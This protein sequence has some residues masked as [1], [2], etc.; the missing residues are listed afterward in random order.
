MVS[1]LVAFW[2]TCLVVIETKKSQALLEDYALVKLLKPTQEQDSWYFAKLISM[3]GSQA[4]ILRINLMQWDLMSGRDITGLLIP[5]LHQG[6]TV[7]AWNWLSVC[8]WAA[9][10]LERPF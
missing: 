10:T 8:R 2:D 6:G 9:D 7:S 1:R 3:V 5:T 4:Q